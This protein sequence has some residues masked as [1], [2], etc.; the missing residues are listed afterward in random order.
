MLYAEVISL[1]TIDTWQKIRKTNE[2]SF[3]QR[4]K[5]SYLVKDLTKFFEIF[6]K[7]VAYNNIK[8]HKKSKVFL[9]IENTFLE[10]LQDFLERRF[11]VAKI[12]SWEN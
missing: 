7:C 8:I 12:I 10:K 1:I 9:F 2:N 3:C 11:L 4:E 5:Y 6:S